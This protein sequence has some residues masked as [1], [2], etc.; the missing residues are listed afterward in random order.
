ML[1]VSDQLSAGSYIRWFWR[2]EGGKGGQSESAG[3]TTI[4][5]TLILL[6]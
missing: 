1:P 6:K 2:P 3:Q 5:F 4:S